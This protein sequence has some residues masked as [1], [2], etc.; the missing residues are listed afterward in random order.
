MHHISDISFEITRYLLNALGLAL[1]R[2]RVRL[3]Y[4]NIAASSK[5]H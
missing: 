2:K 5:T 1:M 3:F 4:Q